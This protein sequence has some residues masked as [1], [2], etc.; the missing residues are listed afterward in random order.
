MEIFHAISHEISGQYVTKFTACFEV[1]LIER[2]TD[3]NL[4][5]KQYDMNRLQYEGHL[6]QTVLNRKSDFN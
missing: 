1:V 6:H 3:V 2:L 5:L 4:S